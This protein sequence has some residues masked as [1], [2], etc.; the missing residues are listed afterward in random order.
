MNRDCLTKLAKIKNRRKYFVKK[1]DQVVSKI[2]V[3]NYGQCVCCGS[4]ERLGC[5]HLFTR[6]AYSTRWDIEP[7]GN[8]YCQAWPCNFRHEYDPYPLT[9]YFLKRFGQEKYDDLHRR[10]VTPRKYT[11]AE[12]EELLEALHKKISEM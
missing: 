11:T 7:G 2:M 12:L 1:L 8:C 3:K 5:G 4:T 10:H 9:R 6:Q